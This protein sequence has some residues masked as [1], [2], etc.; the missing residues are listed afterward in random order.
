MLFLTYIQG[1]LVN[2][3]VKGVNAWLHNQIISQHWATNDKRLW[4]RT[5]GAFNCQYADVLEQEK[6]QA[7]L[8]KG[9]QLKNG[10][11]DALI[12]QFETLVR[13]ANYDVNQPLV[14]QIFTNALPH[15]MYGYIINHVKPCDYEGWREA[16]IQQQKT[17]VHMKSRLNRF[18][19][20]TAKPANQFS[21]WKPNNQ[22]GRPNMGWQADPNIMDTTPDRIRGRLADAEEILPGGNRHEECNRRREGR[23]VPRKV[24]TCYNCG[25]IGHFARDCRQPKCNNYP[26]N[27]G[28]SRTRQGSTN[29]EH[30]YAARSIVD[31]RGNVGERTPQQKAHDWLSG[32]AEENDE[33]KD[34]V[35][36]E[37]WKKE[38]FQST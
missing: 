25:K 9:L 38:D 10:D 32:V 31:D 7:E 24:L 37:L 16:A 34:L 3:W 14:M 15:A 4:D 6:A 22:W 17:W 33:V 13:H 2:E 12:T 30:Y 36:Q 20:R 27:A 8:A 21:N 29:E 5:I 26:T 19:P 18:A 11:L 23:I 1:P 35:M 28:P